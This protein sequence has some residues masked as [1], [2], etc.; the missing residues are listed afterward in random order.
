MVGISEKAYWAMLSHCYREYPFEACGL[1]IGHSGKVNICYPAENEA[2]SARTYTVRPQDVLG[3]QKKAEE[4]GLDVVGVFHSHTH[5]EAFPSPTDVRLAPDDKWI[6]AIV[7]L[8]RPLAEVRAFH[9]VNSAI[10][11]V[12]LGLVRGLDLDNG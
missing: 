8:S 12:R 9:I 3:A 7:S 10:T 4:L 6:Y 11:E 1:L 2:K 5:S